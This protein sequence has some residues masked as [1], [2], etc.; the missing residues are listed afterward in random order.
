MVV[1][2]DRRTPIQSP[3]HYR[4]YYGHPKKVTLVLGN[5]MKVVHTV[6]H[7]HAFSGR[8]LYAV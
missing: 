7:S 4:P 8:E 3:K 1:S 6:L 5:L 2:L